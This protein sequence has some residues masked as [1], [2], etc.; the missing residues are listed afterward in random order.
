MKLYITFATSAGAYRFTCSNE[1]VGT[2]PDLPPGEGYADCRIHKWM[3]QPGRYTYHLFAGP[4]LMPADSVK[5]AGAIDVEA[6]DFYGTGVL[7]DRGR[8]GGIWVDYTWST[9]NGMLFELDHAAREREVPQT[10]ERTTQ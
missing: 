3:L 10:S 4:T 2:V 7:P 6:G 5:D 1:A 8:D 9:N